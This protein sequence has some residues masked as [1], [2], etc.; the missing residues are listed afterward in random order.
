MFKSKWIG[1]CLAFAVLSSS[2]VVF[3]EEPKFSDINNSYAKASIINLYDQGIMKGVSAERFAPEQEIT[4]KDFAVVIAKTL[5]IQPVFPDRPSFLDLDTTQPEY[6][7]VEALVQLEL[8]AGTGEGKFLGE[9]PITRQDTAVILYQTFGNDTY[10]KTAVSSYIDEGEIVAYAKKAVAFVTEKSLMIGQ[11]KR[12]LPN[13]TLTRG[14]TA[15]IA[16]KIFER[17][18]L[19]GDYFWGLSPSE[20]SVRV[21]EQK[22]IH[23]L[24][25][26][27]LLAY[28][29]VFGLDNP[30]L[31]SISQ[32]GVFTG[33]KAGK[34][35]IT[36]NIGSRYHDIVVT[37]HE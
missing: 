14:E 11:D 23:I 13:K 32:E 17:G 28:T 24:S 4:R 3:A 25:Q 35:L 33:A 6:G 18:N 29:P 36:V 30:A 15:V 26:K 37:V 2:T 31:G 7:Y 27:E 19:V 16:N 10:T 8:L 9:K 20:I 12:F 22:E 5:G 1:G 34:G 21:G